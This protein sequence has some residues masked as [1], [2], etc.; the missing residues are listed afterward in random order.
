MCFVIAWSIVTQWLK[1]RTPDGG[2]N[3]LLP[4]IS[5]GA[6]ISSETQALL[7]GSYRSVQTADPVKTVTQKVSQ[8]KED[9]LCD[10]C[11]EED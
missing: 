6:E 11:S 4:R 9:I 10:S 8:Q 2:Y 1:S 7:K 3:S 5:F